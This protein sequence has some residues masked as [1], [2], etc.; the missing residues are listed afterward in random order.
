MSEFTTTLV[1]PSRP[2]FDDARLAIAGF[3]VRY[4]GG[5]RIRHKAELKYL[6]TWCAESHLKG[7]RRSPRPPRA[8][9]THDGRPRSG[10]RSDRLTV[11]TVTGFYASP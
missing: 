8:V 3:L 4:S 1:P 10:P 7:L 11:S 2:L 9:G 5:F 6:F